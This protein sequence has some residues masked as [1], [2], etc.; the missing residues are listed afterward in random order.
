MFAIP[1]CLKGKGVPS[2]SSQ[3]SYG[4]V[5]LRTK[6]DGRNLLTSSL[7]NQRKIKCYLME[8]T[9]FGGF[10]QLT[11]SLIIITSEPA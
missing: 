1:T 3:N 4:A 10:Q 11:N 5:Q 2:I 9:L 6:Q 7:L 8:A